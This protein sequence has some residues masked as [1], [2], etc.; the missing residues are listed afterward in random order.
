M[1]I[2]ALQ[3]PVEPPK[4]YEIVELPEIKFIYPEALV[5]RSGT[6]TYPSRPFQCTRYAK[7]K[8]PDIPNQ[9]G[10]ADKWYQYL[11]SQ[12]WPVG[13]EPL[14]GAIAQTK[15]GMHVS[16]V[17]QVDGDMIYISER[18]YDYRGSYRERW[19]PAQSYYFIY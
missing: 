10:N 18:N 19:V 5:D 7:E 12:G 11:K 16:Y 9:L 3:E 4:T 1:A 13:E 14:V 6:N 8:R 17:E 2:V 15:R